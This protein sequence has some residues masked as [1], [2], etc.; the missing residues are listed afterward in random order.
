VGDAKGVPEHDV[1]IVDGF[2]LRVED[3]GGEAMGGGSG[4]LRDVAAGGVDLFVGVYG[5]GLVNG[6]RKL[7]GKRRRTNI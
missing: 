2:V 4:G 7:K 1:G 6:L 5:D 3:P